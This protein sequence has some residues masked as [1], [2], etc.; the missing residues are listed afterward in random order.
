MVAVPSRTLAQR[1][2]GLSAHLLHRAGLLVGVALLGPRVGVHVVA[3]L[4]P[5]ARRIDVEELERAQP[6]RRFPEVELRQDEPQ[7]PAVGRLAVL[8]VVLEREHRA[9]VAE[10]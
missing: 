6:L 3:V 8:A 10:A 7:G 5:E 2:R 4:L 9:V 1:A